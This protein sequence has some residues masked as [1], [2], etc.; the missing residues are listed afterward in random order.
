MKFAFTVVLLALAAMT[1]TALALPALV[2]VAEDLPCAS[3][4]LTC[5]AE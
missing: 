2:E 5:A 4:C 3:W 1:V